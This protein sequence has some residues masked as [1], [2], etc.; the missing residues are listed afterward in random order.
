MN[1]QVQLCKKLVTTLFLLF[2]LLLPITWRLVLRHYGGIETDVK[3]DEK[4]SMSSSSQKRYFEFDF[5]VRMTTTTFGKKWATLKTSKEKNEKRPKSVS[6][7]EWKVMLKWATSGLF[8]M[9]IFC[10]FFWQLVN[11]EKMFDTISDDC[12]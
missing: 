2:R 4:I 12:I 1:A 9:P 8:F 3:A 5:R 10:I 11:R 7:I 6:D